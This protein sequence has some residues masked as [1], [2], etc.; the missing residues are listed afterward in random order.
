MQFVRIIV[1]VSHHISLNVTLSQQALGHHPFILVHRSDP[2]GRQ[3]TIMTDDGM[4]LV[5]LGLAPGR[6]TVTGLLVFGATADHQWLAVDYPE[7]TRTSGCYN[8]TFRFSQQ[9]PH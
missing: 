1:A 6:S 8:A 4:Y 7:Q 3:R 9:S 5:A 2:P